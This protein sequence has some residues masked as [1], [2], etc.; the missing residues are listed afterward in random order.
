MRKTVVPM[1]LLVVVFAGACGPEPIGSRPEDRGAVPAR[2]VGSADGGTGRAQ[3]SDACA[4]VDAAAPRETPPTP[5]AGVPTPDAGAPPPDAGAP[6]PDAGAPTPDAGARA[7]HAGEIA[8]V[9]VLVNPTG[10]DVGREWIEIASLAAEPLDLSTLHIADAA[11]DVATPVAL[12]APGGRAVLGQSVDAATNGGA[13]VTV[14]YGTRLALNNDGEELSLCL[15]PC[16][17]GVVL[18]RVTWGD[19]GAAYDGHALLLDRGAATT[20]AAAQP[21]GTAGDFG[22]PGAPDGSCPRP[23]GGI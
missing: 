23:D 18:D 11:V 12:V 3:P 19:L 22:T 17:E 2:E 16:A 6:T 7:P 10:Q 8:I 13:P 21:F 20:C 5:D 1:I 4:T 9:E 14:A 15:G